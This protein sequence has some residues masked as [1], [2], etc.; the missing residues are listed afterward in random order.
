MKTLM[1]N[2][3]EE[4]VFIPHSYLNNKGVWTEVNFDNLNWFKDRKDWLKKVVSITDIGVK[5]D[6]FHLVSVG[7]KSDKEHFDLDT[8][9][10]RA[11]DIK[12]NV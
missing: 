4:N 12:L 11:L 1:I 6:S 3:Q 9:L 7:F 2:S 10:Y 8:I 5:Q